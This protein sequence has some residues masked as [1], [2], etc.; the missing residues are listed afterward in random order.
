VLIG[1][2]LL[3]SSLLHLEHVTIGF[4][5][6][7][8]LTAQIAPAAAQFGGPPDYGLFLRQAMAR[9]RAV[10]DVVSA[11]I[12]I[13]PPL[14]GTA[15]WRSPYEAAGEAADVGSQHPIATVDGIGSGYFETLR[16]P[17]IRGREFTDADLASPVPLA[18]VS[19]SL[20]DRTWPGRDPIGRRIR[21]RSDSV[22]TADVWR[23]VIGVVGDMRYRELTVSTPAIYMPYPEADD[24]ATYLVVR[25]RDAGASMYGAFLAALRA[26][27]PNVW[28][29]GLEPVTDVYAAPLARPRLDAS[30]LMTFAGIALLL[31]AAGIYGLAAAFVRLRQREIGVRMALG[32]R[33]D[34]VVRLVSGEGLALACIGVVVGSVTGMLATRSL[35]SVLY[36]VTP[37][38]PATFVVVSVFVAIVAAVALYVP[39]RRAA[40]LN[41][42]EALRA[43][44]T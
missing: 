21:I 27:N 8:L 3:I 35:R 28:L 39:S 10:P 25:V 19:Q 43:D 16:V 30:L 13:I 22:A 34:D 4:Q 5:P 44:G 37:T 38:D 2:A 29:L 1:A 36:G 26:V 11:S 12:E 33:P 20:A 41:P 9:L 15:G 6:E 17:V 14:F 24:V 23:T 42:A 7:R 18:I 40:R 32:A 31:A